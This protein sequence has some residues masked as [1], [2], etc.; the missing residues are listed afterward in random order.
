L[1][2]AIRHRVVGKLHPIGLIAEALEWQ[3][4]EPAPDLKN[5]FESVG[6]INS[7]SRAAMNTFTSQITWLAREEGAI[8]TVA[9][10]IDD[11]LGLLHTDLELRGFAVTSEVRSDVRVSLNALRNV[12]TAAL[13]AI[14]DSTPAPAELVLSAAVA[15]NDV[16]LSIL[17]ETGDGEASGLE[18]SDSYRRI[19]WSDVQALA[20]AE[21]VE[22][23]RSGERVE[24]RYSI[25]DATIPASSGAAR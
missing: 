9:E 17:V 20:G 13:I 7:L 8:T 14:T 6:R 25:K 23:S 16:L 12:L 15:K 18:H 1:A 11:C 22:L 24:I 10:G 4:Q 2:P 21:S 19:E 3:M 5:A